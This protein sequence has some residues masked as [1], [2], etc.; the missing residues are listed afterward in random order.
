MRLLCG[1]CMCVCDKYVRLSAECQYRA[2]AAIGNG[3][4]TWCLKQAVC[5]STLT[6]AGFQDHAALSVCFMRAEC[7]PALTVC[8]SVGLVFLFTDSEGRRGSKYL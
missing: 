7:Q 8:P 5:D 4:V 2:V 3:L 6:L 1:A